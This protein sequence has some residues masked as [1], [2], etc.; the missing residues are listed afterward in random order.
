[1]REILFALLILGVGV[2]QAANTP[3][4]GRKGGISHCMG[5]YFICNDGTTSQSKKV[6]SADDYPAPDKK[7]APGKKKTKN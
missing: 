5:Q 1:M 2:A 3:C 7:A 4:S 6:C